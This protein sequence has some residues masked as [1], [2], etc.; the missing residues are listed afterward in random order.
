MI[1]RKGARRECGEAWCDWEVCDDWEVCK[2]EWGRGYRGGEVMG[3]GRNGG[4]YNKCAGEMVLIG[5]W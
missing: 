3:L 1:Y 5:R 2:Q 4:E